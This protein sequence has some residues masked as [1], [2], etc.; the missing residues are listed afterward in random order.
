MMEY[1]PEFVASLLR[2][3][4]SPPEATFDNI[5]DLLRWLNVDSGDEDGG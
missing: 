5:E 4:E 2:A 1:D 3:S